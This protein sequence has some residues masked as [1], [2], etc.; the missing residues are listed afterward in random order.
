MN[1]NEGI[2]LFS[3]CGL[4]IGPIIGSAILLLPPIV[5][6]KI[7]DWAIVAWLVIMVLGSVFAYVFIYLSLESPGNEGVAL[8]V[9]KTMGPF[10]QELCSN[11]LTTAVFFGPMAVLLTAAGFLK[12]FSFLKT[13]NSEIIVCILVFICIGLLVSGVKSF[14]RFN[15]LVTACTVVTLAAG[16]LYTLVTVADI[17]VPQT[18]VSLPD[19]GYSLLLLFWAIVGWEVIGNYIEDIKNP[20]KTLLKAMTIS[21]I[22]ITGAYLLVALALQS[23]L[24]EHTIIAIMKPLFGRLAVPLLS[25][26]AAGLCISTYLM[27]VGA[28]SRMNAKRAK[29]GRLPAYLA[30][31]NRYGSPVNAIFTLA[32]IHMITLSLVAGDVLTLDSL[33][34]CAN[35][36]FLANAM[37]GLA[38]GFRIL[39]NV[40]LKFAISILMI[41]FAGLLSKATLWSLLIFVLVVF[42]SWKAHRR[43]KL[44]RKAEPVYRSDMH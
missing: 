35:V 14:A 44:T 11:F 18:M 27:I 8:A 43:H 28:V 16:S 13:V 30:Q 37:I 5:Y 34:A 7:G 25:I 15:L 12:N 1:K 2:G 6:D 41:A 10:W 26:V 17:Q 42:I 36:F 21:V 33:V 22:I 29:N 24:G 4:I 20:E 39:D 3:L 9:G 19:F 40:K 32:G 38:A 23:F 31:T